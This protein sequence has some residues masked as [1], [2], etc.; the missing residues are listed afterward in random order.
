[1]LGACSATSSPEPTSPPSTRTGPSTLS[2][3]SSSTTPL[4]VAVGAGDPPA[5]AL[6]GRSPTGLPAQEAIT[7]TRVDG[8]GHL[9][10][11]G[12]V[13]THHHLYQWLTRGWAQDSILFDW[14]VALYPAWS[15]I[16]ADLTRS[17]ALGAMGVLARSGCSTVADHHYVFPRGSGDI[18]GGIVDAAG[19]L[20]LRLHATRGSMDL[21]E[22]RGGLRRTSPSRPRRPRCRRA[23]RRSS[24]TTTPPPTRWCGSRSRRARRSR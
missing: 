3:T 18:V 21:G 11:P 22:S 12:L 9:L 7:L 20:G 6:D 10:T 2:A 19:T 8:R 13:N 17:A 24:A 23:E 4:I 16:D 14:L 15:R 1:M 5:W